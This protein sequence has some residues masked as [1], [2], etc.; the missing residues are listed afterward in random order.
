[1]NC[2]TVYYDWG[3]EGKK[4]QVPMMECDNNWY[5]IGYPDV[6]VTV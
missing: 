5:D 3:G 1:M 4:K 6:V 2:F